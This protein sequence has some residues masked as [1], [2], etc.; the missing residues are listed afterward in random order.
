MTKQLL[1]SIA[2][3]AGASWATA[4]TADTARPSV[5]FEF[6]R[7]YAPDSGNILGEGTSQEYTVVNEDGLSANTAANFNH[8]GHSE[9][10]AR[11]YPAGRRFTVSATTTYTHVDL[12]IF[13]SDDGIISDDPRRCDAL[14]R[15]TPMAGH[16][17]A[18]TQVVRRLGDCDLQVLDTATGAP[19]DD[20]D[21]SNHPGSPRH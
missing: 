19:P 21:V 2:V 9:L 11:Q 4:A 14:A 10:R 16:T 12:D 13:H 8:F 20:I 5:T 15:F 18:I 6:H 17:Y 1:F 7:G 3:L